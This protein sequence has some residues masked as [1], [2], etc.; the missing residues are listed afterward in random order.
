MPVFSC[1]NH[2]PRLCR[3][4]P[5]AYLSR[6]IHVCPPLL[7]DH[8]CEILKRRVFLPELGLAFRQ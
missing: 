2:L 5:L 8:V 7:L 6:D 4:W 1:L 3:C